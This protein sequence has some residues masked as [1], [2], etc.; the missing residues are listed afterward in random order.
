MTDDTRPPD[1]A[2][3]ARLAAENA[4]LRRELARLTAPAAPTLVRKGSDRHVYLRSD[5][6]DA[7]FFAEHR[8]DILKAAS[9]GRI[10]DDM[11][12]WR[13]SRRKEGAK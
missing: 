12:D 5:L 11:P 1:A 3:A 13:T 9:E 6:T 7:R 10:V 4:E 8:A 2:E